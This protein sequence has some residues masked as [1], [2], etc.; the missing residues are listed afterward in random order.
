M[1]AAVIREFGP[2]EVLA[3]TELAAPRPADGEALLAV[4]FANITFVE[5]QI[6]AGRP[7]HP[8]M[9]PPLPAVLGN[10]VGGTVIAVGPDAD[11]DLMGR[12][13]VASLAGSGG[14]AE[15]A[16][17]ASARLIPVPDGVT[18]RDA[19]ALLADGRTAM[20]LLGRADVRHGDTVVIEAAAGG[21]G[22]LL[23]QLAHNAGARVVALA[24]G[25]RKMA[26][27]AELGADVTVDYRTGDW[28][29]Q[30]RDA[31]G[32]ADVV[33]DGVGGDVGAKAFG[34]LRPG[35]RFCPFGMA[36]GGFAPVTADMARA[37]RVDVRSGGPMSPTESVALSRAALDEAAAGRLRPVIGQEH[38]LS[39]AAAAHTAIEARATIGK[40]LLTVA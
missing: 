34:L 36:S 12:A 40:T 26:L 37:A 8:S 5:T 24:G 39:E 17:T 16:A 22:T 30:V 35:G 13:V 25:E 4:T 7:P 1:H 29:S 33:F 20:G 21:V 3:L 14:Y 38:P 10:G 18:M 31:V 6:R 19:V 27:A 15:Q 23:V 11:P 2:P 9:L 28:P 32:A